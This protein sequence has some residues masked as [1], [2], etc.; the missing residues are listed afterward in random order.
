MTWWCQSR[1]AGCDAVICDG[2][3]RSGKTLSL[4]IG[5]FLWAAAR[6]RGE[7]FA[8]CGKTITSLRR[9]V[10]REIIPRL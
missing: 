5:F 8:L 6:F 9:N 3:V 7:Q 2:A 1:Y 10:L 4:G